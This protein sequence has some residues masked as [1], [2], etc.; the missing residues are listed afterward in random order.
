MGNVWD[1]FLDTI[2]SLWPILEWGEITFSYLF[3]FGETPHSA[4][5]KKVAKS[6]QPIILMDPLAQR[7]LSLWDVQSTTPL[8]VCM[9]ISTLGALPLRMVL[10][11]CSSSQ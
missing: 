1:S 7:H 4:Q 8:P 10:D 6:V 3:L 5:S 2:S 9:L 11:E